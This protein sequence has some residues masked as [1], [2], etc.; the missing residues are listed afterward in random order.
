M[1]GQ[2]QVID[3]KP[4]RRREAPSLGGVSE[5]LGKHLRW[6]KLSWAVGRVLDIILKVVNPLYYK[7]CPKACVSLAGWD[8]RENPCQ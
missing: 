3:I 2:E 6:Q 1:C 4:G 7:H 8:R 5:Y